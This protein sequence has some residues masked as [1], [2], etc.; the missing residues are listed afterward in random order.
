M[1]SADVNEIHIVGGGVA[2]ASVICCPVWADAVV[3]DGVRQT[4]AVRH[5]DVAGIHVADAVHDKTSATCSVGV[6][7]KSVAQT[8]SET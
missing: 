3:T 7:D 4:S 5:V 2:V 1:Y 6:A 8:D